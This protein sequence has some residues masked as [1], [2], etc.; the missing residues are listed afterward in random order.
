MSL[1][2]KFTDENVLEKIASYDNH[3][4]MVRD[5]DFLL[6]QMV[7]PLMKVQ[8]AYYKAHKSDVLGDAF[9]GL[10]GSFKN[11]TGVFN[12][13]DKKKVVDDLIGSMNNFNKVASEYFDGLSEDQAS[14]VGGSLSKIYDTWNSFFGIE[15]KFN[16][17]MKLWFD[18]EFRKTEL[19]KQGI[20]YDLFFPLELS[21][22]EVDFAPVVDNLVGNAMK[23]AFVG[24]VRKKYIRIEGHKNENTGDFEVTVYDSGVGVPKE[25]LEKVFEPGFSSGSAEGHGLG[26]GLGL[27]ECQRIV[28]GCGGRIEI[29]SNPDYGTAFKFT[30][31]ADKYK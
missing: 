26:K 2:N 30:I 8:L 10:R 29:L 5:G 18:H 17:G 12:E 9:E 15:T 21:T 13:P 24:D 20:Q 3:E 6:H 27:A 14:T 16:L 1:E 19:E 11:F 4:D 23:Y 31:P 28:E 22:G 25:N 7:G